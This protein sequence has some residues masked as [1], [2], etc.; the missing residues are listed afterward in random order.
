MAKGEGEEM[1]R[2]MENGGKIGCLWFS[3]FFQK[4]GWGSGW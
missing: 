3:L 2:S 4:R 1:G